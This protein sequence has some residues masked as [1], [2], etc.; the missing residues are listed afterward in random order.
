[1]RIL[2]SAYACEPGS[3]SDKEV[4]WQWANNLSLL[5]HEVWVLTRS[6]H[7]QAI[8]EELKKLGSNAGNLHFIYIDAD[9]FIKATKW[10]KGRIYLYY[11][12]WQFNA[13]NIAAKLNKKIKFDLVHHVTWVSFRQP[14]FMGRLGIPFVFGP[15]AGGETAPW[16]LRAGYGIRQ[17]VSDIVR[18]LVNYMA[19]FDPLVR[20][21]Y[22]NAS[23]IYV[24]SEHTLKCIPK[25]Y[26]SK[27]QVKLAIGIDD[28]D[29]GENNRIGG[30]YDAESGRSFRILYVG[31]FVG[32]KGLHL[33]LKAFEVFL[34]HAPEATLTMVGRGPDERLF[35][36]LA[37][38]LRLDGRIEWIPW[39]KR[40]ELPRIYRSHDVFLYPSLHDSGALTVLEAMSNGLPVVCL[41]LGGPG[42]I[43]DNGSGICIDVEGKPKSAVVEELADAMRRLHDD[44]DFL[45]RVS[46]GAINRSKYFTWNGLV[47]SIYP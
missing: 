10:M 5:G 46:A 12:L 2:L 28:I 4:G 6:I 35:R 27:A 17:W 33:G 34:R 15:V 7:K 20:S 44:L 30:L 24:T 3:G 39:V 1:M 23:H 8:E 38:S 13:K 42:A 32:W 37:S 40:D 19:R 25:K 11:Y 47:R 14:S 36:K 29:G 43:V 21:T 22:K 9:W 45:A 31:R 26:R 41:N 16:S 18:D